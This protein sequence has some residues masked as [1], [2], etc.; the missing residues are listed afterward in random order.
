MNLGIYREGINDNLSQ[1]RNLDMKKLISSYENKVNNEIIS[2]EVNFSNWDQVAS[3]FSSHEDM[4]SSD[5]SRPLYNTMMSD[6]YKR[7]KTEKGKLEVKTFLLT[8]AKI[9][10][11]KAL[12]LL[13]DL[14]NESNKKTD[15]N[16]DKMQIL[17]P[18]ERGNYPS[19]TTMINR[20]KEILNIT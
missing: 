4:K 11:F 1:K 9:K 15:K 8:K 17:S 20:L 6:F 3:Y 16:I 10:G 14:E 2:L 12:M 5:I 13:I 7:Y 18:D 19:H